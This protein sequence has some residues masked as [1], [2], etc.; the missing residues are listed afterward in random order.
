MA[1][2]IKLEADCF[3]SN[4]RIA[5]HLFDFKIEVLE[6]LR[7]YREQSRFIHP[8]NADHRCIVV[9]IVVNVNFKAFQVFLLGTWFCNSQS[10]QELD[11]PIGFATLSRSRWRPQVSVMKW[12]WKPRLAAMTLQSM[13]STCTR[14]GM[15]HRTVLCL[16]SALQSH[17]LVALHCI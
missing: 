9:A 12:L 14:S 8:F 1:D 10:P 7:N 16:S 4:L 6:C 17:Q 2:L 15:R 5:S 3:H 11:A 13:L